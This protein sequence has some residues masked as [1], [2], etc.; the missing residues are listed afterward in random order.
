MTVPIDRPIGS[1][2]PKHD[3]IIYPI[4]YGFIPKVLGGDGEGLDVYLMMI[5]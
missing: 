4:N 5:L 2:H 1:A 3:D